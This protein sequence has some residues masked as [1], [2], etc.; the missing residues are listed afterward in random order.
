M[1]FHHLLKV[2]R[3]WKTLTMRYI[4]FKEKSRYPIAILIKPQQLRKPDILQHY[5][6]PTGIPSDK[7]ITMDLQFNGK[8]APVKLCKECLREVLPELCNLRVEHVL[9]CDSAYF[10]VLTKQTK[11]EP[12]YGYSLPCKLPGYEHLNIILCPNYAGLFYDPA[13][14]A[15][16]DLALNALITKYEGTYT[17]LGK[18]IIHSAYYPRTPEEIRLWLDSL[19]QYPILTSDIEGFSLKFYQCGI[20]SIGFAWD[21]H[22]GGA[23]A[24]DY[25][26]N[27]IEAGLIRS[28]LKDFFESYKGTFIWHNASFD[29]TVLVY[30][31]WMKGFLDQVGLL[32]G[33]DVMCRNFHDTKI[34][35]YLATNSCA[36]NEL[37]L[38]SQ[39]H[40]FAGNY[41]EEDIND[42]TKIPVDE[43][44]EYN[45]V[46]CLSTW[47]VAN[48]H[49][50]TMV[51]DNQLEIYET[52][53]IPSIKNIIQMQLTGMPLDM[54]EVLKVEEMMLAEREVFITD[55]K[56]NQSVHVL[57]DMLKKAHIA[58]RNSELKTKQIC[59]TDA[60]V[61]A[62]EFNPNSNPQM[63]TLIYEILGLPVID[64][65]DSKQ[66]ATG[67]D[68]LNKLINHTSDE[69]A[70]ELLSNLIKFSK[71][72]KIVTS[73][74]PAFK[75]AP[76]AEDGHHYLFGN[77]NLGG[78]V[79]GRLSSSNV[80]LQQLPS[81]G[82][83]YAKP[84]KKCF[85]APKGWLFI[86]LDFASLEDRI[87]ALTTKDPNKLKVYIDK[88]DGHSLRAY[89][90][91]G[92]SMPDIENTVESINSIADKY[93]HLRQDSKAPTFA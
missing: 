21:E 25:T 2:S 11:A 53:M 7:F 57:V 60:E 9:V 54:E 81:S 46:D 41:A 44:L 77:F 5:V 37:G 23:F 42:I 43:L 8:K 84:I 39:A 82:S 32:T 71:V 72:E 79:S 18:D 59:E 68:T 34:I 14:Q 51:L 64:L 66:P 88:Y 52:L 56:Q 74:I 70:K 15:K 85:K 65:T 16:M 29:L 33:L 27:P 76:L 50:H 61:L 91:F 47:Y 78:T 13:I 35:S 87:S 67:A 90:Y 92:D 22:N 75:E 20:G 86:G 55:I 62:I 30:Q 80:N 48:K 17:D 38:K 36:G 40:E 24:V 73:F 6:T 31:L 58:K 3:Q 12:H 49:S 83:P 10:K 69:S 45:L 28:Y 1:T 63:Q 26:N 93:K 4:T 89:A 19:H